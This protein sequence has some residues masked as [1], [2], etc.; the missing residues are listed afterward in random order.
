MKIIIFTEG[1]R[2]FYDHFTGL[3]ISAKKSKNIDFYFFI[4]KNETIN[5]DLIIRKYKSCPNI[6]FYSDNSLFKNFIW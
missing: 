5:H 1:Y 6:H 4:T 3:L 2:P